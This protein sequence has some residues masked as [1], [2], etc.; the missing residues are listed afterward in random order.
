MRIFSIIFVGAVFAISGCSSV[1]LTPV[2]DSGLPPVVSAT[3]VGEPIGYAALPAQTPSGTQSEIASV[4]VA[5]VSR[6]QSEALLRVVNFDFDSYV[7]DTKYTQSLS[8][9]AIYMREHPRATL[10]LEGHTD[11]LGGRSYNVALGQRRAEAVE[12]ALSLLG[13]SSQVMESVSY[14]EERPISEGD[15]EAAY[16]QNRRVEFILH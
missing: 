14:G 10:T 8:D 1:S 11:K 7:V 16:A 3:P 2:E 5:D 6:S 15:D 12:K 4:E 9:F 13:V